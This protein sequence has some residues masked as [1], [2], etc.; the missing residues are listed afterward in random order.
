FV[1]S[2][3]E[4]NYRLSIEYVGD[5]V[6]GEANFFVVPFK[7]NYQLSYLLQRV[8]SRLSR[9]GVGS[10]ASRDS[11]LCLAAVIEHPLKSRGWVLQDEAEF[12][13]PNLHDFVEELL[14]V[15]VPGIGQ[16]F[17]LDG[18]EIAAEPTSGFSVDIAVDDVHLTVAQ[19]FEL[20]FIVVRAEECP[21]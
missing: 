14:A 18:S 1:V 11:G 13:D 16:I 9:L 17:V 4:L 10:F 3:E 15:L 19:E 20:M 2:F 6:D 8:W 21:R 12:L 5:V 7:P